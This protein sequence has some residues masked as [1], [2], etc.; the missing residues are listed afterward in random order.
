MCGSIAAYKS[1]DLARRLRE[2]GAEIRVVMTAAAREFI[3]PL[4]M[5]A[6]SG[7][8]VRGEL[9]DPAAEAAMGHIE[10]AR[11][12]EL[13]LI[14]PATADC[15]A[16]LAHGLADDLLTTLCLASQAPLLLAP[17]MNQQM[18]AAAATQA[19]YRTLQLRGVRFA[20]PGSGEQACGDIG[21]GRML[22]PL[23]IIQYAEAALLPQHFRGRRV[24]ITAGPTRENL[25]PA[26]FLSNR[27]SGKMGYA[28]ARA[29]WLAGAEVTLVSG[30]VALPPPVGAHLV[31]AYSA[32][33]MLQ[34]VMA[35]VRACDIFIACAA[36]ADYRP[37][38]EAMQKIKKTEAELSLPLERTADILAQVAALSQPPFTVGFAAETEDLEHYARDKLE[39]K[40]L[41]MIAA[42]QVG[43]GLGFESDYNAL[44]VFWRGGQQELPR[45]GKD[46]LA[47]QLIELIGQQING[48]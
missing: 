28:L 34:A 42:N 38:Q 9:F 43:A 4:T 7:Q 13:I 18:W 23:D 35:R 44:R 2:R 6:V 12:A 21:S 8:P 40:R 10:L 37:A 15:M 45:T 19:N 16:K 31:K 14:A 33:D 26:R 27:S 41:D 29:A 47:W 20:G 22:E 36:V 17:A 46:R 3:T 30:P 11:W 24:L 1:A 48:K 25:D 5:Q 39:R 32:E